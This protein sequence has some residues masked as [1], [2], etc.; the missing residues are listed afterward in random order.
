MNT[1][2]FVVC[3]NSFPSIQF[4]IYIDA[5][6]PLGECRL[7]QT[8]YT[9]YHIAIGLSTVFKKFFKIS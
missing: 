1:F 7:N 3:F 2:V 8:A 5:E 9:F 4:L 6:L